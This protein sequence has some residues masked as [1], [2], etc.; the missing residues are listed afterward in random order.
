MQHLAGLINVLVT[1]KESDMKQLYEHGLVEQVS[2]LFAE[3]AA[4]CLSSGAD[5]NVDVKA[6]CVM[7]LSLLDTLH[8]VLKFVSDVVRKAL[9]VRACDVVVVSASLLC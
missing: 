2:N 7:L 9:Q 4:I 8:A 3:V 6:P 5:V 1:H